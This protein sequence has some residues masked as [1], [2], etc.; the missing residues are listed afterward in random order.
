MVGFHANLS[1]E[2]LNCGELWPV[3]C[4]SLFMQGGRTNF[5]PVA[6]H[7]WNGEV[8]STTLQALIAALTTKRSEVPFNNIRF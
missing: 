6:T 1:S 5:T 3:N 8:G 4:R 7:K 2:A